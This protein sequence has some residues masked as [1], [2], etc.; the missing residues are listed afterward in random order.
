MV[1]KIVGLE[2]IACPAAPEAGLDVG[3]AVV[4][5]QP[6]GIV[7][8]V[9]DRETDPTAP[10]GFFPAAEVHGGR[11]ALAVVDPGPVEL[12]DA[13]VLAVFAAA[14]GLGL[15]LGDG[16]HAAA[17]EDK[18]AAFA[19]GAAAAACGVFA[20]AGRDLAAVDNEASPGGVAAADTGFAAVTAAFPAVGA[21]QEGALV[22]LRVGPDRQAAVF[23]QLEA[24][25]DGEGNSVAEDEVHLALD[26]DALKPLRV[27]VGCVPAA[28]LERHLVPEELVRIALLL[29][30]IL[31]R[32]VLV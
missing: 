4:V 16:G 14:N 23:G 17:P 31:L 5:V 2:I 3:L 11:T 27:G 10:A 12:Q 26:R 20:A 21:G 8:I 28:V 9:A 18:G 15:A 32:G 13:A 30:C 6:G 22:V 19:A 29:L 25:Q 1:V 24:P 7:V